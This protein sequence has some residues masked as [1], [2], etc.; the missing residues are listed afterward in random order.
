MFVANQISPR[1]VASAG[2]GAESLLTSSASEQNR[3][4]KDQSKVCHE[5]QKV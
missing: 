4:P 1:R 5:R 3:W 2:E